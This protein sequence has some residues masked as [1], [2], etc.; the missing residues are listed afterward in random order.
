MRGVRYANIKSNHSKINLIWLTKNNNS[1]N[2]RHSCFRLLYYRVDWDT[3][4]DGCC[5]WF[6][7]TSFMR[8]PSSHS[9]SRLNIRTISVRFHKAV[10]KSITSSVRITHNSIST[11]EGIDA[12]AL[13]LQ[14]GR[15]IYSWY[16]WW[17]RGPCFWYTW[18]GRGPCFWYAWW[19]YVPQV[20]SPAG[21]C[22]KASLPSVSGLYVVA[23]DILF[24]CF[25]S[26][27]LT[28]KSEL[29]L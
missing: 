16:T 11:R 27:S 9:R 8:I 25:K 14:W 2:W 29:L 17:G 18:W 3:R 24:S 26:V 23:I 13:Y 10:V 15:D 28:L 6:Q 19:R 5:C 20:G 22:W 21:I 12:G 4:N 7:I 1:S